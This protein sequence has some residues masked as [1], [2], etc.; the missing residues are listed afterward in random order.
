M[1]KGERYLSIDIFKALG[2][3]YLIF[4]HQTMWFFIFG[5][6]GGLRYEEALPFIS[7]F[8]KTSGLHVLGLQLPL[9]AGMTFYLWVR[10]KKPSWVRLIQRAF[11][12]MGLGFLM[13]FLTWGLPIFFSWDVLPFVAVSMLMTFLFVQKGIYGLNF[14]ILAVLGVG[15]FFCSDLFPFSFLENHYFYIILFG[16]PRGNHYWP[17]CPWISVF[18]LGILMGK[19]FKENDIKKIK[20]LPWLGIIFMMMSFLSGH[21]YPE[22]TIDQV[23]GSK[24]FKPSSFFVLGVMGFSLFSISLIEILLRRF[25]FLKELIARSGFIFYSYGILWVYLLT[26]I[27][28]YHLTTNVILRFYPTFFE[29]KIFLI[30]VIFIHLIYSYF[31]GQYLY[32]LKVH[33]Q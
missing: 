26:T 32:R 19:T 1:I 6:I 13:N 4:L 18:I 27:I 30:A 33:S 8:A 11:I 5:D 24:L 23:W 14:C 9:L 22:S 17:L 16:D 31:I 3:I 15:A 2:I 7:Y 12:L 20:L 28:G 25:S 21:F 10:T 29:A